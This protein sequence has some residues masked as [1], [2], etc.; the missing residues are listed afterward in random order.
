MEVLSPHRQ[1]GKARRRLRLQANPL[2]CRRLGLRRRC[3]GHPSRS[4]HRIRRSMLPFHHQQRTSTT[5]TARRCA[6]PVQRPYAPA[7]RVTDD[8]STKKVT[9]S[10]AS[11]SRSRQ[12][13]HCDRPLLDR[14]DE[15]AID[16]G[17]P[18]APTSFAC[19]ASVSYQA[20]RS[21]RS[22]ASRIRGLV[23]TV[24]GSL[25]SPKNQRRR[26]SYSL[27]SRSILNHSKDRRRPR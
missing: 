20:P 5:R 12:L 1:M 7:N 10:P 18:T 6:R 9:E 14:G 23:C 2:P 25:V 22:H 19:R 27:E 3:L 21:F 8:I 4:G 11:E 17:T 26:P 15:F 24:S 13:R 16:R